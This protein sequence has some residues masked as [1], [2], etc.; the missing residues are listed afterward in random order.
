[1]ITVKIFAVERRELGLT[2]EAKMNFSF[3]RSLSQRFVGALPAK[4]KGLNSALHGIN[5]VLPITLLTDI[6]LL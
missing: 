3:T 1:M 6:W 4:S 5:S 2:L